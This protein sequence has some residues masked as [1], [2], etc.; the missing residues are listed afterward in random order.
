MSD[1]YGFRRIDFEFDGRNAIV[2][3]PEKSNGKL[4]LKTE[5]FG[6]FPDVEVQLVKNGF[7]LAHVKNTNRWGTEDNVD[8]QADFIRYLAVEYHLSPKAVLV[9]M[10]CGG[11]EAIYVAAKYPECVSVLYLDAPLMNFSSWPAKMGIAA[12]ESNWDEFYKARGIS[13]SELL[14]YREHPIDKVPLLKEHNIPVILVYG[15][16]DK[17]VPYTENGIVLEQFYRENNLCIKVI[18]KPGCEHHPHGLENPEPI[19]NF[20]LEHTK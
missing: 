16:S 2:V 14:I 6:A 15:D 1:F 7:T 18:R 9:G 11:M 17:I 13:K 20:I 10:S 4:V 8:R 19:V 5:Y 12:G 3:L